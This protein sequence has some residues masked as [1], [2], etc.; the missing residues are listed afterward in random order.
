MGR[1]GVMGGQYECPHRRR[2][3]PPACRA[4]Q[5]TTLTSPC[6]QR[7]GGGAVDKLVSAPLTLAPLLG[8][9]THDRMRAPV[10]HLCFLAPP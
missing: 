9:A 8:A 5:M 2:R 6:V 7:S 1:K 10:T 4:T 3:T